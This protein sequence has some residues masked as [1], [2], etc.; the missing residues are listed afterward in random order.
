MI[1][2]S[3]L[4]LAPIPKKLQPRSG[5]FQT[6]SNHY[7]HLRASNPRDLIPAINKLDLD[8]EITASPKAPRN[9]VGL[10]IRL[11]ESAK[12]PAQGYKLSISESG[13]E[14]LSSDAA[15]AFYGACTLTQILSQCENE[16]PCLSIT[17]K[18][19]FPARG[20]MIDISRDK[21]PTMETLYYLVDLL[22]DW[23]IN[24]LQLYTEHTFAYTAH[25]TVWEHAN[26]MTG[27]EIMALD[28]YCK[29]RFIE[30]VP[31]QNSFG[32]M[33]RW[34]KHEKYLPLA[35]APKGCKESNYPVSL[36]PTDKRS[37]QLIEGLYDELLPHFSSRLFNVGCDETWDLGYG[38]NKKK[39]KEIGLGR[40]YLDFLLKIYNAVKSRGKT[41]MFWGDIILKHPE[42][43]PELPKDAIA[44]EWGYEYDHPFLKNSGKFAASKIPFYVCPGTSSWT[45][46][47]GRTNNSIGNITAAARIGLKQGAI[48]LLNTDWGDYGHWQPLSVSYLPFMVGAMA[49]WN[50]TKNLR[51]NLTESV[52][53]HAFGDR[54]GKIG[55]AFYDLGNIYTSFKKQTS[56]SS[57]PWQMLFS[58]NSMNPEGP[59]IEEFEE[60]EHRLDEIG[61]AVQE[62]EMTCIDAEVVVEEL[63]HL[64]RLLHLAAEIG[65]HRLGGHKPKNLEQRIEELKMDHEL[66]WLMR[67]RIGG[68]ADSLSKIAIDES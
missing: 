29:E 41:M 43:I 54:T 44:L 8:W 63:E 56:N 36:N 2:A 66:V 40:L 68:L 27:G 14:I 1:T 48:G 5:V 31:N 58:P 39:A 45:T 67:N 23:K 12:I 35:E 24:Q 20:V 22:A 4:K 11:D 26:P 15:G 28:V 62:N 42:L 64:M 38:K 49:S 34:F 18:P 21:V 32:H 19:D 25:P 57:I 37:I 30:L 52:S 61:E 47:V 53:I 60:M 50:A 55:K 65:R 3:E 46:L 17:D 9:L 59:A 6:M 7:I 16:I 33:E 51:P 13:M 10:T